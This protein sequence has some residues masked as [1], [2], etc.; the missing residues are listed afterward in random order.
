M[1]NGMRTFAY[2]IFCYRI[3]DSVASARAGYIDPSTLESS[4]SNS[5]Q[6]TANA[7]AAEETETYVTP[8]APNKRR[9]KS[10]VSKAARRGY[11]K[12]GRKRH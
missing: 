6:D 11:G 7:Y 1:E 12:S 3:I 10:T 4:V 5:L 9:N 8:A 2:R